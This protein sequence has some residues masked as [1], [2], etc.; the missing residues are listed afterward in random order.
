MVQTQLESVG[1]LR[2]PILKGS[3]AAHVG[4]IGGPK[5]TVLQCSDEL[6]EFVLKFGRPFEPQP[7]P[8]QY[9]MRRPRAAFANAT[10]LA[11]TQN[12]RYVEGFAITQ[13][14]SP[15]CHHAWCVDENDQVIDATWGEGGAYFGVVFDSVIACRWHGR[16]QKAMGFAASVWAESG[17][18]VPLLPNA[19]P[20]KSMRFE[21]AAKAA[22]RLDPV[23]VGVL[24]NGPGRYVVFGEDKET[25]KPIRAAIAN[26]GMTISKETEQFG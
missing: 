1:R 23:P 3:I 13:G 12:L 15:L 16:P 4:V 25:K 8:P 5:R 10:F 9:E 19:G 2:P 20:E 7:L 26:K 11:V 22:W 6:H 24:P 17:N 18:K 14:V 21:R